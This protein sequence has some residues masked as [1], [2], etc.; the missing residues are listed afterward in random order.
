MT[1]HNINITLTSLC[2]SS[3]AQLSFSASLWQMGQQDTG[4][5][6]LEFSSGC[7][8]ILKTEFQQ[9]TQLHWSQAP[10]E[11]LLKDARK[12]NPVS[13][14][15]WALWVNTYWVAINSFYWV[16]EVLH[17]V[18]FSDCCFCT[19]VKVIFQCGAVQRRDRRLDQ[20]WSSRGK[21][22]EWMN[23]SSSYALSFLHYNQLSQHLLSYKLA[24]WGEWDKPNYRL[25]S[26]GYRTWLLSK[27]Q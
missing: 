7:W 8:N 15:L 27:A 12:L 18:G 4:T 13:T 20:P 23:E 17:L 6:T 21:T 11:Q 24:A 16:T 19:E 22:F 25:P 1:N 3:T 10:S 2:I 26:P 5:I 14:V 9:A